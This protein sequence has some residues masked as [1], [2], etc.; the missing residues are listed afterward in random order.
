MKTKAVS[1][2]CVPACPGPPLPSWLPH[3]TI[4]GL[5]PGAVP[6]DF[7]SPSRLLTPGVWVPVGGRVHSQGKAIA[8]NAFLEGTKPA[9]RGPAGPSYED[10]YGEGPRGGRG[11]PAGWC[12]PAD[13]ARAQLWVSG[14][15][16][17]VCRVPCCIPT[18]CRE[19]PAC[20]A[21]RARRNGSSRP[22]PSCPANSL[23]VLRLQRSR[24]QR[25]PG[26]AP[27]STSTCACRCCVLLLGAAALVPDCQGSDVRGEA[28]AWNVAV[29]A[30]SCASETDP[31]TCGGKAPRLSLRRAAAH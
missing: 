16:G 24:C 8:L 6:G 23:F 7:S 10:D 1:F 17:S 31:P 13:T 9:G 25:V 21:W 12:L 19:L 4:L 29:I 22:C 5:C 3:G 15:C 11:A 18:T 14:V 20:R 28:L 2:H 27:V 26:L 30:P